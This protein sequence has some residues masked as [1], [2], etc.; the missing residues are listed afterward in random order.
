MKRVLNEWNVSTFLCP[1]LYTHPPAHTNAET[2]LLYP[3]S[4]TAV[5]SVSPLIT[6]IP[7]S[8]SLALSLGLRR[9]TVNHKTCSTL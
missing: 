3:I 6:S 4:M 2:Y 1:P 8:H 9:H 7:S 5:S